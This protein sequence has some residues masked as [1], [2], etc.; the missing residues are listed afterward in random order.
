MILSP[1]MGTFDYNLK[2]ST[3]EKSL[4]GEVD[5]NQK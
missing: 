4:H 2:F 1:L 3:R 5:L